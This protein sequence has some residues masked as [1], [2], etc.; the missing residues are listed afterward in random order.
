M[1]RARATP[2]PSASVA[3]SAGASARATK[4]RADGAVSF[5]TRVDVLASDSL[6]CALSL[7][8]FSLTFFAW[9]GWLKLCWGLM[10]C[11]P[12]LENPPQA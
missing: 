5:T 12:T 6:Y 4:R 7:A 10:G 3:L 2:A 9:P 8:T 11:P 1:T